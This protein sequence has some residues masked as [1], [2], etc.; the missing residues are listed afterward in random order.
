MTRRTAR[1]KIMQMLYEVNFH[2]EEERD[3]IIHE[4]IEEIKKEE[5]GSN[6][7]VVA[8]IE[9]EYYGVLEHLE[10]I[11]ELIESTAENGVLG[12]LLR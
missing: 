12:V 6:K 11:G 8:F 5:K 4:C 10:V 3:R 1:E 9:E 2:P 7:A